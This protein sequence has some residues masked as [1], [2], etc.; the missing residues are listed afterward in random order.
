MR[1]SFGVQQSDSFS[2]LFMPI[3]F[4]GGLTD[5]ATGLVRFGYRDYDPSVGRFTA[6]DPVTMNDPS[7]LFPPLLLFLGGKALALGIAAAGAYG[8][9]WVADRIKSA[10]DGKKSDDAVEAMNTVAPKV[11]AAST[12]A[13]AASAVPGVA[14]MAPGAVTAAGQ[15]IG[16]AIHTSRHADTIIK[17]APRAKD[18]I[19]GLVMP[20][21]PAMTAWGAAGY[22]INKLYE[23][24]KKGK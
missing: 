18:F 2:D 14:V 5:P 1:D 4:A 21:P 23:G 16:A 20:G 24:A 22:G 8:S 15:R 9:A 6:P 7:G 19:E 3:G 17:A 13:S 11:V 12:A 10:R